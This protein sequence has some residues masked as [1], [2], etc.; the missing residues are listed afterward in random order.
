M[1]HGFLSG[2]LSGVLNQPFGN[3][4]HSF[5]QRKLPHPKHRNNASQIQ[6]LQQSSFKEKIRLVISV[7]QSDAC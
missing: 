3:F 2:L 1:K 6:I 5:F 7:A 4:W